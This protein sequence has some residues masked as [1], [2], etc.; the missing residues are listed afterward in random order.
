MYESLE[1]TLRNADSDLAGPGVWGWVPETAFI[2]LI[3][4]DSAGSWDAC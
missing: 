1:N 3:G 2:V 4:D